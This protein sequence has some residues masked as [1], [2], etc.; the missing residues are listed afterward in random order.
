MNNTI[1]K[2]VN[3]ITIAFIITAIIALSAIGYI[4]YQKMVVQPV[5]PVSPDDGKSVTEAK[6]DSVLF[7][8]EK[9]TLVTVGEYTYLDDNSC[10]KICFINGFD[11]SLYPYYKDG[12]FEITN[13]LGSE[14]DLSSDGGN[15]ED[16]I[17]CIV[18][19][20]GKELVPTSEEV[21]AQSFYIYQT[22]KYEGVTPTDEVEVIIYN[23]FNNTK[24]VYPIN[25]NRVTYA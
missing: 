13:S 4:V 6:Y 20:N 24:V 7:N 19:C 2:K 8:D 25:I 22:Y 14:F 12:K 18:K 3:P 21:S 23:F 15:I 11:M 16:G 9:S 5:V 10:S 17:V 1:S